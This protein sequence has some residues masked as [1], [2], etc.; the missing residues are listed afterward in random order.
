MAGFPVH[1]TPILTPHLYYHIE[2]LQAT[3]KFFEDTLL[4][5]DAPRPFET[6]QNHPRYN[7][8]NLFNQY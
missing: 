6:Q 4:K 5:M 7:P 1:W 2:Q 8:R 3:V